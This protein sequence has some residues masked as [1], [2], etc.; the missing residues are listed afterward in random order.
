MP[1]KQNKAHT[2]NQNLNTKSYRWS[3][4]GVASLPEGKLGSTFGAAVCKIQAKKHYTESFPSA[5]KDKSFSQGER[6]AV[7]LSLDCACPLEV[8]LGTRPSKNR[9]G[10]SGKQGG[11]E[12]YTAEC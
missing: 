1:V 6:S 10:G 5:P 3:S 12:M 4:W 8:S 2:I 9:K 11:M 7:Q